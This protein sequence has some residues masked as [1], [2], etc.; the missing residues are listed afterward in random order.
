MMP[1]MDA[2]G[3]RAAQI[4]DPRIAGVPVLI[5]SA[6]GNLARHAQRLGAA[7]YIEKPMKLDVILRE[8]GQRCG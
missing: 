8:V 6:G 4:A 5:V 7:G 3:F 1:G 2:S